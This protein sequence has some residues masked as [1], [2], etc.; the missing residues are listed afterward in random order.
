[1]SAARD[2]ARLSLVRNTA[3]RLVEFFALKRNVVILLLAI[4]VIGAG[5]ELW[6]RFVPKY[7]QALGAAPFIIGL[8][9]AI[10]T[11]LGAI[12]AWPGGIVADRVGHR[13]ALV[14]FN[15]VSVIGY[16]VVLLVPHWGAVLAGTFL[17][18][19][20]SCFSLPAT[21]SLIGAALHQQKHAMGIGVQ[22]VIKR[23]PIIVGPICGGVLID[24]FGIVSGVRIALA[25]TIV[26]G[27]ATILLQRRLGDEK[28]ETP[29]QGLHF[30]RV[31]SDFPPA[32]RRLLVSDILIRFCERI[33]YAWVVIYA[34][35]NAGMTATQV[36]MLTAIEVATSVFCLIPAAYLA[37]KY[38]RE[39]FVIATFVFF[40]AFPLALLA[41][42]DFAWLSV[43]FATR[44]LKEFGEPARKALIIGLAPSVA[45]ART[46]GAYYLIRDLIVTGGAFIG[47]GLWRI[48][49]GVNF[50][51]AAAFGAVG[52]IFYS[53]TYPSAPR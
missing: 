32:L 7:L 21:F 1:V 26:L 48:S 2:F 40:T 6:M 4:I 35:D 29:F 16:A 50:W 53:F 47:A 11:L 36:G 19:A 27:I 51:S 9:D 5:E 20:W 18:L 41:A 33:P 43:A 44:G 13:R 12:Y 24:R 14:A 25:I 30:W 34:M 15:V 8:Y 28:S 45:R 10:K 17:F 37:D 38:G 23:L 52:T 22:S 3:R 49:P 39:P 42:H 46:I 31:V